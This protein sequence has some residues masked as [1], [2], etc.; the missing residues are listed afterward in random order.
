MQWQWWCVAVQVALLQPDAR[1]TT[2]Q[3]PPVADFDDPK[4]V[5][6][7]TLDDKC[8]AQQIGT[9]PAWCSAV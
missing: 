4:L 1:A 9:A 5:K 7:V 3:D 8:I 2:L 6:L